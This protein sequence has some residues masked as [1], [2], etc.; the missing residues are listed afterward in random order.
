MARARTNGIRLWDQVTL[1]LP[2]GMRDQINEI[3]AQNGRSANAEIVARLQASM[4]SADT[5]SLEAVR[6]VVREEV[7]AALS[8]AKS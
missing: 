4:A 8:E 6:Q 5:T 1:R 7:R 3:A 2:P